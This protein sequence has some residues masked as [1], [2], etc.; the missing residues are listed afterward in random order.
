MRRGSA[1]R[2]RSPYTRSLPVQ[3]VGETMQVVRQPAA[4]IG[5]I[6]DRDR[7]FPPQNFRQDA[8]MRWIQMLYQ[9][10]GHPAFFRQVMEEIGECFQASGRRADANDGKKLRAATLRRRTAS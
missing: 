8:T 4:A 10:K 5:P 6:P 2:S 7:R 3:L 9:H 1:V